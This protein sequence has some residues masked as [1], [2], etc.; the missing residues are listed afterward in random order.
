M[1]DKLLDLFIKKEMGGLS[2]VYLKKKKLKKKSLLQLFY[3]LWLG[4]WA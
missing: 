2:S 1:G 4:I 3:F